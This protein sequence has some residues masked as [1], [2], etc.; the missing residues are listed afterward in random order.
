MKKHEAIEADVSSYRERIQAVAELALEVEAEN[1]YD[2]KRVAAQRDNVLR[3]WG[4]LSQLLRA[5]RARL[6]QHLALQRV[7]QE[8]VYMIDWMEEMQVLGGGPTS[9]YGGPNGRWG[10]LLGNGGPNGMWGVQVYMIDWMEEMQVLGGG[11]TLGCGGSQWDTRGPNGKWGVPMEYRGSQWDT[12]GPGLHDRLDG[13]DA[14]GG[15][16]PHLGIWGVPM[17]YDVI[18]GVPMGYGGVPMEYKWSQRDTG[19]P[20]GIQGVPMGYG[21]PNGRWGVQ[22]YMTDWMEEMQVVGG[23]PTLGCG[24]S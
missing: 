10:V 23:G 12:G 17:G 14:G 13:G 7:F 21:G 22:V 20:N 2:A 18:Q 3:Q 15:G 6:E 16:R 9:G 8:M 24:G 5:R 11:P 4:L 19:C 1:Y